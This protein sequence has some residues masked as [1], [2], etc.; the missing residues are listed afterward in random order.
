M[1]MEQLRKDMMA[2]MK[3]A[4][5]GTEGCNFVSGFGSEEKCH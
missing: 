1:Q 2:A 4:R 5:Q 3:S